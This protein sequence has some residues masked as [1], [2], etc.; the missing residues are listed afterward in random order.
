MNKENAIEEKNLIQEVTNRDTIIVK[1]S[2]IGIIT[3]IFLVIFKAT[4][5][6]LSNSIAVILDAVNNLSDALSSVI[7]IVGT[8]LAN[9]LPN[10][11]HPLG[12]GRIEYMSAMLVSAIVLYAGITSVIESIKRIVHP[13][14]ADYSIIS[15][16]II[17][18]AVVVKVLL[19]K[20]VKIQGKKVNSGALLASGSDAMFDALLSAS[21]LISAI[22]YFTTKISLEAY[23]GV[24]I[25]T[26]IIKAGIEMMKETLND[27]L[28]KRADAKTT[29]K[30]KQLLIEESEVKGAYDL[31]IHNYGPNKNLASVHLELPDIMTVEQ[32]DVLTRKLQ[33]KVYHETGVILVGVG[34]YSYNTKNNEISKIYN[35]IQETVMAYNWVLQIH[36]FYVDIEKKEIR[37]DI[38][39]NFEIEPKEGIKIIREKL[40]T[41]YP[42]YKIQIIPDVDISD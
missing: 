19:G 7:T 26:V 16:I 6:L 18:V 27:I 24:I 8:K 4:I 10:K 17:A 30:I 11:K 13:E 31:I 38:V 21:V 33:T 28:G 14:P 1:T 2:I 23:V 41:M 25:S 40:V 35:T 5:G 20:Y 37:F 12:Y 39:M 36:G 29:K 32:V 34:V 3:N 42:E 15:L 22:I 9:K